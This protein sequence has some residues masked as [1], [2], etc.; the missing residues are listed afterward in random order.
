MIIEPTITILKSEYDILIASAKRVVELDNLVVELRAEI[1][2][3]RAEVKSLKEEIHFLK[4]G[5][6]SKNSSTPPSH[7]L[8]RSNGK[9]LRE[10]GNK[11]SGGQKGHEGSTL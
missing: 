11:K 9:S 1:V 2:C 8:G 5:K 3:L 7:D 10:V 4:N 6:N